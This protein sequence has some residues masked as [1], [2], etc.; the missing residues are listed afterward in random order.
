[1]HFVEMHLHPASLAVTVFYT[2]QALIKTGLGKAKR[3]NKPTKPSFDV[4][5]G[6]GVAYNFHR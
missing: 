3:A 2:I 5:V 6:Y 4:R 1:M